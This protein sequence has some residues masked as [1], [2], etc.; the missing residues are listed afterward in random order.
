MEASG[1]GRWLISQDA[2][3]Q[4]QNVLR[5]A[6]QSPQGALNHMDKQG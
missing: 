4:T 2:R 3:R 6:S 1:Y 5:A